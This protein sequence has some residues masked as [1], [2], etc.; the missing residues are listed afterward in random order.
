[1][2][3]NVKVMGSHPKITTKKIVAFVL[4]VLA[5]LLVYVKLSEM[6]LHFP[7]HLLNT[8]KMMWRHLMVFVKLRLFHSHSSV[9]EV[10]RMTAH[11]FEMY[12]QKPT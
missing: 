12:A 2:D 7:K 8:L 1:M 10:F 11:F 4:G 5:H 3:S 9:P 6:Y